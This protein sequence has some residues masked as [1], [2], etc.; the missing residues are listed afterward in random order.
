[1]LDR[2]IIRTERLDIRPFI[3]ADLSAVLSFNSNP[4]ARRFMGGV[5]SKSDTESSLRAHIDTVETTGLG[6]RAV[7]E[8]G[9]D[10]VVGYCGMQQ[11]AETEEIELFYGYLPVT[12][13]RGVATEAAL[14]LLP[15][16]QR[17]EAVGHL[18]AIV[19][20]E[21]A[22]SIRVLEKVRFLHAGTYIHPRWG[23]EHLRLQLITS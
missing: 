18:V 7:V 19:H 3:D 8:R 1:M 5:V 4:Q 12:W 13:G 10:S 14:G 9:S 20:P 15:L 2:A 16:A 23:I 6:A 21:N 22:A 17:C 11:F